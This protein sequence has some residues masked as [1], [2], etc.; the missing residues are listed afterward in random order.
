MTTIDIKNEITKAL[1][2]VPDNILVDILDLIKEVQSDV[3]KSTLPSK[4][5]KVLSEDSD[6]LD[7]LAQ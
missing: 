5:K 6:L 4:L 7:R 1:D 3:S 2:H